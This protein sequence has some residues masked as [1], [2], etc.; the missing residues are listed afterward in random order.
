V[1]LSCKKNQRDSGSGAENRS[2]LV[3]KSRATAQEARMT[4][5]LPRSFVTVRNPD[6]M[7]YRARKSQCQGPYGAVDNMMM[8]TRDDELR[9]MAELRDEGNYGNRQESP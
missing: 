1:P 2:V 5:P 3:V 6:K 7:N 4:S 8:L 9:V